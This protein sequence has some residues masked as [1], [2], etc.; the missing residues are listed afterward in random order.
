MD[1]KHISTPLRLRETVTF[2]RG[3]RCP[4]RSRG[5]QNNLTAE[6]LQQIADPANKYNMFFS[7]GDL[8]EFG[9]KDSDW[10]EALKAM[11]STTSTIPTKYAVGN[12]DT[13][14]GGLEP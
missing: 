9:F 6:M 5:Q 11:S 3:Q 7:L 12:H 1:K 8:V 2:C 4:F 10:Q 14:L 13:L